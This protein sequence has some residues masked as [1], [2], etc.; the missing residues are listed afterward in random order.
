MDKSTHGSE[1]IRNEKTGTDTVKHI[2]PKFD[3]PK[4]WT[5]DYP[6]ENGNY[7]NK[8]SFCKEY[9]FGYKGRV[10]CKE[11]ANKPSESPPDRT[12]IAI[13]VLREKLEELETTSIGVYE[14]ITGR[15]L[16][17]TYLRK[18]IELLTKK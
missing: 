6:H 9:F 10:V 12:A 5:E 14:G 7:V 8:C 17:I 11:C 4:N 16:D 15:K 18:S 2:M 1:P 13:E 3:S